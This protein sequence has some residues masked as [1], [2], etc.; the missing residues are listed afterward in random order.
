MHS[1]SH[2]QIGP[3]SVS[4]QTISLVRT[5]FDTAGRADARITHDSPFSRPEHN[6]HSL[7]DDPLPLFRSCIH[8]ILLHIA[9]KLKLAR[10]S[11]LAIKCSGT[12]P[13]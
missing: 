4:G 3:R 6:L 11:H 13:I 2:S 1:F 12:L 7:A 8:L 10:L 5:A 9:K